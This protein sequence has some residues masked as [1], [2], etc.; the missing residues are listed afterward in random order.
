M[1]G[2]SNFTVFCAVMEEVGDCTGHD[3]LLSNLWSKELHCEC[4]HLSDF[5]ECQNRGLHS[6]ANRVWRG[7]ADSVG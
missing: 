4:F 5:R 2:P 7:H 3:R 1:E 6:D